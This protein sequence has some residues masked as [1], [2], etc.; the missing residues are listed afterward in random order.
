MEL[1]RRL[2]RELKLAN[3]APVVG[4][5]RALAAGLHRR[6]VTARPA[7]IVGVE[8]GRD[9]RRLLP[10]ELGRLAHPVLRHEAVRRLASG[11]MLQWRKAARERQGRGPFNVLCDASGS[12]RGQQELRI[13]GIAL[14]LLEIARRQRW[15]FAG[16]VFSSK[17]EIATF[18]FPVGRTDP[19][20]LLGF[21]STFF[22]GGTDWES[23]LLQALR[24]QA[25][26]PYRQG[27]VVLITDGVGSCSAPVSPMA[28]RW[29]R[30][31]RGPAGRRGW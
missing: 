22:G 17:D 9:V 30:R 26:S 27:G 28:A 20:A 13:K 14:G 7:E 18:E 10:A 5:M 19:E 2:T 8:R 11:Q 1:A 4:A 29:R 12:A 31:R 15:N 21:A 24:L 23:P 6:R 16:V 25:L 3:M